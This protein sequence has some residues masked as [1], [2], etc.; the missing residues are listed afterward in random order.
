MPKGSDVARLALGEILWRF[1]QEPAGL[2][3]NRRSPPLS[4]PGRAGNTG[5]GSGLAPTAEKAAQTHIAGGIALVPNLAP[6]LPYVVLTGV[7]ALAQI[8]EVPIHVRGRESSA[9]SGKAATRRN[10]ATVA[11]AIP[12]RRAI[13]WQ[14]CPAG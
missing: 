4:V 1:E 5:L 10:L 12:R 8:G 11:R 3:L 7:P 2:G 13:S 6:Q 14:R 9:P